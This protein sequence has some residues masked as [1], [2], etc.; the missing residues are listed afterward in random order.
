[1]KGA[2][3]TEGQARSAKSHSKKEA[4]KPLETANDLRRPNAYLYNWSQMLAKHAKT[5]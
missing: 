4:V 5:R 3:Q 2:G 1:M